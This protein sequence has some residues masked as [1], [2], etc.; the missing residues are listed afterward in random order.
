MTLLNNAIRAGR[1]LSPEL[2]AALSHGLDPSLF[3]VAPT[4]KSKSAA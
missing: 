3:A 1:T 2:T 4:S